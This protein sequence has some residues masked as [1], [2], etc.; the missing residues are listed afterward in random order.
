MYEQNSDF[1]PD[2][3]QLVPYEASQFRFTECADTLLLLIWLRL[4]YE[5]IDE[6]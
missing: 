5:I 2:R 3:S 4:I 6:V 1:Y